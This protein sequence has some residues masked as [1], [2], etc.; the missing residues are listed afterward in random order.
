MAKTVKVDLQKAIESGKWA[1]V[2]GKCSICGKPANGPIGST[3]KGH[4]GRV[5]K[6]Y[7]Q[8]TADPSGDPKYVPLST[9]C[10]KAEEHGKSAGFVV[11]MTGGDAGTTEPTAPIWQVYVWPHG[12]RVRKFLAAGAMDALIKLL[13]AKK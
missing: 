9:L 6:Y 4:V 12:N 7:R 5:G 13:P 10:R 3:C 1:G 11:K 8:L 2:E